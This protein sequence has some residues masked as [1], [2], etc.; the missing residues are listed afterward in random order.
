MCVYEMMQGLHHPHQH[1]GLHIQVAPEVRQSAH[2][3][4]LRYSM[5]Y[6]NT[7]R[8]HIR[9]LFGPR[10][11]SFHKIAYPLGLP[12]TSTAADARNGRLPKLMRSK[13]L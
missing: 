2:G 4:D 10:L 7:G 11:L 6:E 9:I 5:Y 3:D 1:L 13:S 8:F 12:D